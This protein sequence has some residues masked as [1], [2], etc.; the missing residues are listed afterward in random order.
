MSLD[1]KRVCV[2]RDRSVALDR[3]AVAEDRSEEGDTGFWPPVPPSWIDPTM[4]ALETLKRAVA[5]LWCRSAPAHFWKGA[6]MHQP[7][8]RERQFYNLQIAD[9]GYMVPTVFH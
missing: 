5:N 9:M 2:S 3:L 6:E 1:R 7:M 4:P 8:E